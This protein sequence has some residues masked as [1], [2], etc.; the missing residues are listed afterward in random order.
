MKTWV[1]DLTIR[2]AKKSAFPKF[3]HAASIE[4]GG[5]IISIGVNTCKPRTPHSSFS[6]HAEIVS[7]KRLQ[8][9]VARSKK[10]ETYEIYV[11]RVTPGER[12]GLSRPCPKCLKALRASGLIGVVHYTTDNGWGSEEIGR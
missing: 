10:N 3:R 11:A 2:A 6:V 8:T 1:A 5:Q 12:T 4:R 7:L 9:L